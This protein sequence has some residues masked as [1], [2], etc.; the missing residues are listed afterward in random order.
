MTPKQRKKLLAYRR[1]GMG[2]RLI[3]IHLGLKRDCIREFLK[4]QIITGRITALHKAKIIKLRKTGL[5]YKLI[6]GKLG[7][8]R[9]QVRKFV[10]RSKRGR[11]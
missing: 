11:R 3:A 4:N 9:D 1:A 5:G 6:A 8:K 2:Y 10:L 7:L